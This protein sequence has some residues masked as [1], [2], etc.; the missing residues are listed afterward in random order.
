MCKDQGEEVVLIEAFRRGFGMSI[1][2]LE[3]PGERC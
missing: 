3:L 2:G 1:L